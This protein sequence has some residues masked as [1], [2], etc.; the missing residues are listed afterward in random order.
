MEVPLY[1][2][3]VYLAAAQGAVDGSSMYR[4]TYRYPPTLALLLTPMTLLSPLV[5]QRIWTA[6]DQVFLAAALWLSVRLSPRRPSVNE[7]ALLAALTFGFFPLYTQVKVGQMGNALFLLVAL[8]ATAW[9]RGFRER[10]GWAIALAG[11]LKVY[12][13]GFSFWFVRQRAWRAALVAGVGCAAILLVPELLLG[14]GWLE[15]Y[16]RSLPE[17]FSSGASPIKADNQSLFAFVARLPLGASLEWRSAGFAIAT[18]TAAGALALALAF[19]PTG[20]M[21]ADELAISLV[22]TAIPLAWANPV[23]W[24][25]NYIV[26]LLAA[27]ALVVRWSDRMRTAPT[28]GDLFACAMSAAAWVCLSQPYRLPRILGHGEA[29]ADPLAM[30]LRSTFLLGTIVVWIVLLREMRLG[31]STKSLG[32]LAE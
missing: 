21:S 28:R 23:S 10:A 11:A 18:A 1:D 13:L 15:D 2:F 17:M 5:A 30:L 19:S 24:T 14:G 32:S 4:E 26:L 12:P 27:P 25:H 20:A 8:A 29:S 7:I 3:S 9:R 31:R 6:V 22:A 16:V